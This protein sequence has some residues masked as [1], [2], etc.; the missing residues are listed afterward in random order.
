MSDMSFEKKDFYTGKVPK[1]AVKWAFF[2]SIW[3]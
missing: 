2:G 1:N 3:C